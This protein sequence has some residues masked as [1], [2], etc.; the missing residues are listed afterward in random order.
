MR[1]PMLFMLP[2]LTCLAVLPGCSQPKVPD[3]D[4]PPEPQAASSAVAQP[5]QLREAIQKPLDKAEAAKSSVAEDA[6]AQRKAIDAAT[7]N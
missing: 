5:T 1:R 3:H 7:G 4:N 2:L 6:E